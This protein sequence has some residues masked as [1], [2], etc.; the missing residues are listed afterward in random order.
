MLPV[1][2]RLPS[3]LVK[4]SSIKVHLHGARTPCFHR[5]VAPFPCIKKQLAR[6]DHDLNNKAT[7]LRARETSFFT[8]H[9]EQ[10]TARSTRSFV[11]AAIYSTTII[12]Y[13]RANAVVSSNAES[14]DVNRAIER[15][16]DPRRRCLELAYQRR[17][18][19]T[20]DKF[21][22]DKSMRFLATGRICFSSFAVSFL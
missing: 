12:V 10:I 11:L 2:Q 22:V 16:N 20:R 7:T 9:D 15:T 1:T 8:V 5:P 18:S 19:W 17:C 3:V 4:S 21:C 6:S 13:L 14:R